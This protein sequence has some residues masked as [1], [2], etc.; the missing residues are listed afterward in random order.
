MPKYKDQRA[1]DLEG[2]RRLW[3]ESPVGSYGLKEYS[4]RHFEMLTAGIKKQELDVT[5]GNALALTVD[6][7]TEFVVM[8]LEKYLSLVPV[9][10]NPK[11]QPRMLRHEGV[12]YREVL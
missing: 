10:P 1:R 2:L 5:P 6:G 4:F 12:L 11:R 8:T 7:E 9:N 3:Q